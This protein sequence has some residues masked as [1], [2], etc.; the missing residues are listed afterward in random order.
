MQNPFLKYNFICFESP[1]YGKSSGSLSDASF[2]HFGISVY[3]WIK[4]NSK[5]ILMGYS[6]ETG[7]ANYVASEQILLGGTI[8]NFTLDFIK[9]FTDKKGSKKH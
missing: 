6:I 8:L 7:V 1:D 5:I 9:T 3:D 2:K 4:E